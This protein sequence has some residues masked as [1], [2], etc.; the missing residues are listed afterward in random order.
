MVTSGNSGWQVVASPNT[1]FTAN[2]LAG[3]IAITATDAWAVGS[4]GS[5]TRTFIGDTIDQQ[6]V[7]QPLI[8]HWD[9]VQWSIIPGPQLTGQAM[10]YGVAA[11]SPG[12]VWAVGSL[13]NASTVEKTT[14]EET[15]IEHWD[16]AQWQVVPSPQAGASASR[17][18]DVIALAATDV[19][20]VGA[21]TDRPTRDTSRTLS[22]HWDGQQW[23][24][25][26]SLSPGMLQSLEGIAAVAPDDI[27]AVGWVKV[28]SQSPL[29]TLIEHWDGQQWNVIQSPSPGL[30]ENYLSKLVIL[31]ANDIWAV[32]RSSDGHFSARPS[33]GFRIIRTV[34]IEH[35]DG[36]QWSVVK[37]PDLAS[38]DS[39]LLGVA[40]V[41]PGDVWAV[42]V[43]SI[44]DTHQALI[45]H[46]DGQ[47]WSVVPGP[48]PGVFHHLSR[49]VRVP[50][51]SDLWAVG[52]YN[53]HFIPFEHHTLIE[54]FSR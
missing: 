43:S 16:G 53:Q 7:W 20:A 31:A 36:Q 5:M 3:V 26:P 2:S 9:G 32:G 1:G 14:A 39:C 17:L 44:G 13:G 45:E 47:Q 4:T 49:V 10:L 18:A 28:T 52:A 51:S 34:L 40:S 25:M 50:A 22:V 19:W 6:T 15:L 24:V 27:W 41:S 12:D 11:S 35:W 54:T 8:E 38:E 33:G 48:H 30:S 46:W 29:Q 42:G 37:S 23:S 21:A